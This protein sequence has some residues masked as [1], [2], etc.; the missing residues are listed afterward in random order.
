M[1]CFSCCS[2]TSVTSQ[3][4][5]NF[6]HYATR[7]LLIESLGLCQHSQK[8]NFLYLSHTEMVIG[9]ENTILLPSLMISLEECAGL[10]I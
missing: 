7:A 5:S 10:K 4:L 6:I 2:L 1:Y 9:T 3:L 8:I